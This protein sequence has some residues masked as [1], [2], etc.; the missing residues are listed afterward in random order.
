M[1]II[2]LSGM[3]A[4]MLFSDFTMVYDMD[5]GEGMMEEVIR[6]K[7]SKNVKLFFRRPSQEGHDKAT[8]QYVINGT[9]YTVVREDGKL[10]Y[11]NMNKIEEVTDKLT[12][13]LNV[14]KEQERD[15]ENQKPFFK[16]LKKNGTKIIAGIKGEVWTVE[17]QEDGRKYQE[18]IVVTDNKKVVEA[19]GHTFEV[20]NQFGEGPYGMEID[21]ELQ[22]MMMVSKDHVLISAKGMKLKRLDHEKIPDSVFVLPKEAVNGMENLPKMDDA[23]KEAGKKLLKSMLE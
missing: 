18:E 14:S 16:I 20:L 19:M 6:Y 9:R 15:Q 23:K 12:E 8:G 4:S 21:K 7:D 2:I 1:K 3:M 13:E 10:T 5:M 11:M 17:S 22:S